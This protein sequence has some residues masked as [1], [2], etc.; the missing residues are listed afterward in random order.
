MNFN[1]FNTIPGLDNVGQQVDGVFGMSATNGQ[2]A[3]RLDLDEDEFYSFNKQDKTLTSEMMTMDLPIPGIVM[4]KLFTELKVGDIVMYNGNPAFVSSISKN[5]Y[6]LVKKNGR[7]TNVVPIKN[8]MLGNQV[9]VPTIMNFAEGMTGAGSDNQAG[10]FGGGMNPMMMMA[11]MG[12]NDDYEDYPR[13]RR[14]G[15]MDMKS[16][17]M[18]SMMTGGNNPFAGFGQQ[19]NNK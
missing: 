15:G 6:S 9:F 12:D 7:V 2:I 8:S 1:M 10:M 13:K 11:L 16:L 17:M 3:V 5:R 19:N 4:P 18:M 14:S